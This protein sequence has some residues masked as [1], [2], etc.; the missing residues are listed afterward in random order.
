MEAAR[1]MIGL[2]SEVPEGYF[3]HNLLVK[4]VTKA[5]PD[6]RDKVIVRSCRGKGIDGGHLYLRLQRP[7]CG[8]TML[9]PFYHKASMSQMKVAGLLSLIP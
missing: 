5:S 4:P 2:A 6:S 9:F 3:Y 7:S 8:S 1:L